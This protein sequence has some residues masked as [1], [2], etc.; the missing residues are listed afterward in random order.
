MARRLLWN[1]RFEAYPTPHD[2][3]LETYKRLAEGK[4]EGN[5]TS[6]TASHYF[7]LKMKQLLS[8]ESK[9]KV[10]AS[11][12]ARTMSFVEFVPES[13]AESDQ[14]LD[15]DTLG[16]MHQ[17]DAL[18]QSELEPEDPGPEVEQPMVRLR[19]ELEFDPGRPGTAKVKVN[20][21]TH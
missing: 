13:E 19:L 9:K 11:V 21:R 20:G 1:K 15:D 16:D 17:M 12:S 2:L 6:R 8:D 3:V 10:R 4:F 14:M 5:K 7:S 18:E